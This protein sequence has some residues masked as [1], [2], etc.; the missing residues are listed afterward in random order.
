MACAYCGNTIDV[1]LTQPFVTRH[2]NP[3]KM[4]CWIC[5]KEKKLGEYQ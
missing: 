5:R 3:P 4:I 1:K 2:T